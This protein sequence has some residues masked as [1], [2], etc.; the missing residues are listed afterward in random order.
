LCVWEKKPYPVKLQLLYSL[1]SKEEIQEEE[2]E[3]EEEEEG[4]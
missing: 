3:E 2:E 4:D 1:H